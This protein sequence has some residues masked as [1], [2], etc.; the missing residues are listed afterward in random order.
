MDFAGN[1][2]LRV[3][4]YGFLV[5]LGTLG[6]SFNETDKM[7]VFG[8][9]RVRVVGIFRYTLI[10]YPVGKNLEEEIFYFLLKQSPK[11]GLNKGVL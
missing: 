7:A 8:N 6:C 10:Y 11:K 2:I 3:G 1:C 9:F 5:K 4:F